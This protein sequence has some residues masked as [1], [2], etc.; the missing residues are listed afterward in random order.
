MSRQV[1]YVV[2]GGFDPLTPGHVSMITGL[3]GPVHVIFN[4]DAWLVRKKGAAFMPYEDRQ[5]ILFGLKNVKSVV[6]A[7]DTDDTVSKT[8]VFLA[9]SQPDKN[10]VFINSGD[11]KTEDVAEYK[12]ITGKAKPSNLT[13]SG[14]ISEFPQSHSSDYLKKWNATIRTTGKID[15][16]GAIESYLGFDP[17]PTSKFNDDPMYAIRPWGSWMITCESKRTREKLLYILPGKSLSMQKHW[18]RDEY[19]TVLSGQGSINRNDNFKW[20]L[21]P[22]LLH[23]PS[24]TWHQVKNTGSE[25]LVIY[26]L[27]TSKIDGGCMERDIVRL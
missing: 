11:R 8:L 2:S 16:P 21:L 25:P 12:T 23:I 26:E 7:F 17:I 1:E 3:Q 14:I 27:Q 13:F 15:L 10:L 4:T 6:P 22:R 18:Q 20:Q 19:W 24:G 5:A 9:L